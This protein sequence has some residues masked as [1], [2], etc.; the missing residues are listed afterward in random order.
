MQF[1]PSKYLR[2]FMEFLQRSPSPYHVVEEASQYVGAHGFQ[3]LDESES[4][5]QKD[6]MLRLEPGG[7]NFLARHGTALVAL[8]VGRQF[9][10]CLGRAATS[11][12]SFKII[13]AH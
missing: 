8:V 13:A 6:A 9:A 2:S 3:P 10:P 11:A 1:G 4:W 12:D 7:K 5:M